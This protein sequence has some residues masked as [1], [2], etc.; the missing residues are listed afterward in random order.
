MSSEKKIVIFGSGAVAEKYLNLSPVFIVDNNKDLQNTK[1][2]GLEIKEPSVLKNRSHEYEIVVCTTS[3]SEVRSQLSDYGY[4]WGVEASVAPLLE[5][6]MEVANLEDAD[7]EFIISSGLP[8]HVSDLSGGGVFSIKTNGDSLNIKKIYE[9]NVHGL[10]RCNDGYVFNSQGEGIFFLNKKNEVSRLMKVGKGLRPHGIAQYGEG[11]LIVSSYED[12]LIHLSE[13]GEEVKRYTLSDK[14]HKL[15]SPQHHCN[16]VAIYD[17]YAYVSMFSVTG[18][19]KRGSFDGGIVEID[20]S[21]GNKRVINN[22]LTMPHNI[23]MIDDEI[24][25]LNSFK[26]EILGRNFEVWG[27]LP[28]FA[29]GYDENNTYI[30]VGESKNRN[31]SR[32][33]SGRR[34]VSID[35][36]IT[37]INKKYGFSRSIQ[38]PKTISEIHSVIMVD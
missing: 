6:R 38:L 30:I 7:F 12:A 14:S 1:F 17:D 25:V 15:S 27:T 4:K 32:L 10:I 8:S 31:F 33:D 5:E 20:L 26:G 13:S 2:H 37:I 11:W 22:E 36:R 24:R 16:D 29:R 34:P 3:V 18:N 35:T 9:G 19:W 23:M 28:G 21:N